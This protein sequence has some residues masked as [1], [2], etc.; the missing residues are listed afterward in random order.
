M[1]LNVWQTEVFSIDTFYQYSISY[2]ILKAN[3][4]LL[5]SEYH[6]LTVH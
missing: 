1:K 6:G 4:Q 2:G 3:I 5:V